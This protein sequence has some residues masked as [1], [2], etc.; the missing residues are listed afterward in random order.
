MAAASTALAVGAALAVVPLQR[1]ICSMPHLVACLY[2]TVHLE[3][4]FL[5]A[6]GF[7]S[8]VTICAIARHVG[9]KNDEETTTHYF[10]RNFQVLILGGITNSVE[11]YEMFV[12]VF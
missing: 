12:Y 8:A 3:S 1:Y 5:G 11:A 6:L 10:A 4:L 2:N 9:N 7:V